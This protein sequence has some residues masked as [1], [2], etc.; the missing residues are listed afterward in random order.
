[1]Y[2]VDLVSDEGV[3]NKCV[4]LYE[5]FSIRREIPLTAI[6]G[7]ACG[8]LSERH[9]VFYKKM[10]TKKEKGEKWLFCQVQGALG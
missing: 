2:G 7:Y 6:D 1:M 3:W 9:G 10:E 4:F 5:S 8:S